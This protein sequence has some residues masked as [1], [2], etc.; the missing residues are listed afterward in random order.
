MGNAIRLVVGNWISGMMPKRLF[1]STIVNT[2][3][4]SGMNRLK[5]SAPITSRPRVLR[6][7]P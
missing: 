1:S 6:T 2:V 7:K 5:F 4:S 3:K